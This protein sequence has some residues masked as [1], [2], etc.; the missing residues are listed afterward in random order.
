MVF[1]SSNRTN[2]A[3]MSP[4]GSVPFPFL[5]QIGVSLV[6]KLAQSCKY[7]TAPAGEVCDLFVDR[8]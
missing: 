5:G 7:L 2:V 4:D 6:D 8:F 3:I 1:E